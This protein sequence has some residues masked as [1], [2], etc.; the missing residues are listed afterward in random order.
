MSEMCVL[1]YF[2]Y[3]WRQ[4]IHYFYDRHI[5]K[6]FI[7]IIKFFLFA[8][9]LLAIAYLVLYGVIVEVIVLV[10]VYYGSSKFQGI[11]L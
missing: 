4:R 3:Q 11:V 8:E 7:I 1:H 10:A 2:S 5:L 6:L 9:S